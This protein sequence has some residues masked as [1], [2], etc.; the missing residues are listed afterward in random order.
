M[1]CTPDTVAAHMLYENADPYILLEPG[2]YMD[3]TNAFYSSI[4]NRKVRVQG[5]HWHTSKN[6]NVKLEGARVYGYQTSLL[7]ILRENFYVKNAMKW[8]E[9]LSSFLEKEIKLRMKLNTSDYSLDFRHIGINSTLGDLEK[10][11]R[12]PVEVGVLCLS[13]IHI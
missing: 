11:E 13:L 2:G 1:L 8:T 9:K 12:I 6:Y 10:S 5:A 3:V 4:N 7:V